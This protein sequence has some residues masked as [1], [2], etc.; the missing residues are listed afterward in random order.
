MPFS[1]SPSCRR[2]VPLQEVRLQTSFRPKIT[3]PCPS[4][5]PPTR[6]DCSTSSSC[7]CWRIF[8]RAQAS[9]CMMPPPLQVMRSRMCDS[10]VR[11]I[12]IIYDAFHNEMKCGLER[13]RSR[14][15]RCASDR[16]RMASA[17]LPPH[18]PDAPPPRP[19]PSH[20]QGRC[21]RL[22]PPV[23]RPPAAVEPGG[24]VRVT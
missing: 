9:G 7:T 17:R 12:T 8:T 5:S 24:G 20:R 22:R 13:V 6:T 16:P 15:R 21:E 11:A 10:K 23:C 14:R 1:S 4:S 2:P 18:P 3:K 19:R